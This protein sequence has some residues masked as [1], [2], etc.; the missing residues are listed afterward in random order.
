MEVT[1]T[2][3][4]A[5][6][7][8]NSEENI[9]KDLSFSVR[10]GELLAVVGAVG[11]GKS[12][13]LLTILGELIV[14]SGSAIIK[15]RISY[16]CQDTWTFAG[17]IRENII[18]GSDEI[19]APDPFGSTLSLSS[20]LHV[21][22]D[23][24]K[25]TGKKVSF[26][27]QQPKRPEEMMVK[28]ASLK[29]YW[30]YIK[31]GAGWFLLPLI[32]FV[33]VATQVLFTAS[34][35]WLSEWTDSEER[36]HWNISTTIH[37]FVD[38][39]S[40]EGNIIIYTIQI[41]VLFI[42][43]LSR[44]VLFFVICMRA[45]V[46]LHDR[47][48]RGIVR[49][50]ISFFDKN[51]IGIILNRCSRDMGIIDDLLPPT[52]FDA[53][54]ILSNDIGIAIL[55]AYIDCTVLFPTLLLFIVFLFVRRL[56]VKVAK[57]VKRL[58]GITRSPVFTHLSTSLYGLTTIR[59]FNSQTRFEKKFDGYQDIHTAAWFLYISASRWFIVILDWICVFYITA[60][61]VAMVLNID[62][63]S[64]SE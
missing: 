37:T 47:L 12:S 22:E 11:S 23:R 39:F 1:F 50:P 32:S 63:R 60:I 40:I 31:S 33:M 8:Q 28:T 54:G 49:A 16:A 52:A 24:V 48:F 29:A 20:S 53:C 36:K 30:V 43:S 17:S 56:Y 25:Q 18:Y 13:I 44:A 51:P 55:V 62:E 57:D 26:E 64:G 45:S 6:W 34:D 38:D 9:L 21:E 10:P 61:T 4:S 19:I 41:V 7:I 27:E 14:K 46:K 58:E 35:W 15:G 42:L 5:S 2:K 59:A 3:L